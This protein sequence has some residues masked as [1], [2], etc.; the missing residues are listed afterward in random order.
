MVGGIVLVD[1]S[2]VASQIAVGVVGVGG[3]AEDDGGG[4]GGGHGDVGV[5]GADVGGGQRVGSG[6]TRDIEGSVGVDGAG[7]PIH[8]DGTDGVVDGTGDRDRGTGPGAGDDLVQIVERVGDVEAEFGADD[9]VSGSVVAVAGGVGGAGGG[10]GGE[11]VGVVVHF[12]RE[13]S[14]AARRKPQGPSQWLSGR[15]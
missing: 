3:V 4:A 5:G 7:L 9:G 15:P 8:R 6:D 12:H 13:S 10:D 1:E 2:C 14:L 11:L